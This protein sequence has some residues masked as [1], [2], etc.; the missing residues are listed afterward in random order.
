MN[1][2]SID[3]MVSTFAA[4][5]LHQKT[6]IQIFGGDNEEVGSKI[7]KRQASINAGLVRDLGSVAVG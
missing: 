7:A 4:Q 3:A 1:D 6:T 5:Q 2:Q